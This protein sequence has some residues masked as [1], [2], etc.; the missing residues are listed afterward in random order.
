MRR[1]TVDKLPTTTPNKFLEVS[2]YYDQGGMNFFS[3]TSK[4]RGYYLSVTPI[5]I[6]GVF[7]K[8]TAFSGTCDLLE[9][10]KRYSAGKLSAWASKARIQPQYKILVDHVTAKNNIVLAGAPAA[11]PAKEFQ[12]VASDA[13]AAGSDKSTPRVEGDGA[14]NVSSVKSV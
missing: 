4:R 8:S 6:D 14:Q 10:V 7:T 9:E 3:G 12:A 1:I 11:E 5:E 2:V 13:C